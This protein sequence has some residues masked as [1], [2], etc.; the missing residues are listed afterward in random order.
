MLA[1]AT[2]SRVIMSNNI[3]PRFQFNFRVYFN[4]IFMD[5]NNKTHVHCDWT[6]GV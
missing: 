2:K 6:W 5:N 4:L 3:W 1:M